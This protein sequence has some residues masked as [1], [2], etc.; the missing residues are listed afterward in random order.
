MDVRHV[1]QVPPGSSSVSLAT[2]DQAGTQIVTDEVVGRGAW[3]ATD[4]AI[5]VGAGTV[6]AIGAVL[7]W[8]FRPAHSVHALRRRALGTDSPAGPDPVVGA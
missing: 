3:T 7:C 2:A 6:A 1:V 4:S 8:L 5:L